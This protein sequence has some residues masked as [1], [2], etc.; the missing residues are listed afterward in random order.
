[1]QQSCM[2]TTYTVTGDSMVVSAI[3]HRR[4]TVQTDISIM[5]CGARRRYPRSHINVK[6]LKG[7]LS[8]RLSSWLGFGFSKRDWEPR[9]VRSRFVAIP[10]RSE[11]TLLDSES[12]WKNCA[13]E[14]ALPSSSYRR[15][16]FLAGVRSITKCLEV[17]ISRRQEKGIRN[18]WRF[19]LIFNTNLFNRYHVGTVTILPWQ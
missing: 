3:V 4:N 10:A 8:M 17:R 13:A 16:V 15:W 6:S 14:T 12:I 7:Q 1:M 9:W 18:V 5:G 19:G 11:V 2:Y